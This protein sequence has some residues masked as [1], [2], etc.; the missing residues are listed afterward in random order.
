MDL[1]SR[2]WLNM[3]YFV[4]LFQISIHKLQINVFTQWIVNA[5]IIETVFLS[6]DKADITLYGN[7]AVIS[8]SVYICP[9]R[10]HCTVNRL[11]RK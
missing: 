10:I 2:S 1:K 8:L 9:E 3:D 5:K 7:S 4:D 6:I 11:I